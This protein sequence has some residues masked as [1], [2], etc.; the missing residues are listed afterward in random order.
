MYDLFGVSLTCLTFTK[1]HKIS[2]LTHSSRRCLRIDTFAIPL[3]MKFAYFGAT[4]SLIIDGR[5]LNSVNSDNLQEFCTDEE[6]T[7][8]STLD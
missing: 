8:P 5:S 4:K 3:W 7:F 6:F 2:T 1:A